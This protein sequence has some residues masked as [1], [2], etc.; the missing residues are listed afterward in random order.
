V[1]TAFQHA[2]QYTPTLGTADYSFPDGFEATGQSVLAGDLL[3]L[4][5]TFSI[6]QS[7]WNANPN[8][9]YYSPST[10]GWTPL[11][12]TASRFTTVTSRWATGLQAWW[13]FAT[14]ADKGIAT[15]T[16]ENDQVLTGLVFRD[17]DK[18]RPVFTG[19]PNTGGTG[20]QLLT[21]AAFD[22]PAF[23]SSRFSLHCTI[24]HQA[25]LDTDI[26]G[27]STGW[28]RRTVFVDTILG[29]GLY[30]K[31]MAAPGDTLTIT[32]DHYKAISFALA[33]RK[34]GGPHIGLVRSGARG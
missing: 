7:T 19:G 27:D 26:V 31:A 34:I 24:T 16:R 1:T 20:P 25:G 12:K 15:G 30:T 33:A 10:G 23:N 11:A 3:V 17:P 32:R 18:P 6:N 5:S 29:M 28:T 4:V 14:D 13:K 8:P 2:K 9:P 22:M 21:P